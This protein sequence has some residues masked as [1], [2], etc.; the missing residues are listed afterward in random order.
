MKRKILS[1]LLVL[2][3]GVSI[4]TGCTQNDTKP[5]E[6]DKKTEEAGFKEMTGDELVKLNSGKEKD[7]MLIID[8]RPEE[9]YLAGHVAHAINILSDDI[10]NNLDKLEAYKDKK[11]VTICNTGKRSAAAAKVLVENGFKDVYNAAGVKDFTYDLVK[12]RD[13]LAKDLLELKKEDGAVLVDYRPKD[14]YE[15]GHID[16][17]I[18]IELDKISENLDKLP[19]EGKI[20]LY[21]NTGTQSAK[22]AK[23]LED[24]GYTNVYNSVEGTKEYEFEL[25]K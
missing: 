15:K 18:N 12:Y 25:V 4:I 23:E 19:K 7:N 10:A 22:A 21:C 24:A 14:L 5:A 20:L 2:V 9:E 16:G 11:V 3:M 6:T 8:V 17:A 13:I 1:L